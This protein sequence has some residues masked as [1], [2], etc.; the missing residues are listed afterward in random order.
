MNKNLN[1]ENFFNEM[2]MKYPLIMK[3]F[4]EWI[5][6]YKKEVSWDKLFGNNIDA[7][8]YNV[9]QI[10]FHDIPF[11]MQL[12]VIE[13]FLLPYGVGLTKPS[14]SLDEIKKDLDTCFEYVE[15][16]LNLEINKNR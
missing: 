13:S 2:T 12:G 11:E 10:K 5:D 15:A 1:K 8:H 7:I 4:S 3:V 16:K 9:Y 14:I 6:V